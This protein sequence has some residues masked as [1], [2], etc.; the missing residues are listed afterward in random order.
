MVVFLDTS[1]L[2]KRYILEDGSKIVDNFYLPENDI[3]I[4]S[5][6]II[7]INA[8]LKRKLTDGSI[9]IETFN[10][11]IAFWK[12]DYTQYRVIPYNDLLINKSLS[13]IETYQIKTLDSI[14]I[15][16]A[17]LSEAEICA[18]SDE[19]MFKILKAILADKAI[20]I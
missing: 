9:S 6:T 17:I 11:A 1:S 12:T 7:E 16:S 5:V 15:S 19:K 10:N 14:Q 4:S 8:A 2:I 13:I 18:T 20:L 3:C